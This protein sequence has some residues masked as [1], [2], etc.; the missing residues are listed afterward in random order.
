MI[1]REL[2]ITAKQGDLYDILKQKQTVQLAIQS[3][4]V[5]GAN[6][7]YKVTK[8]IKQYRETRHEK[9]SN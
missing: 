1:K 6:S 5:L 3:I 2:W 9:I 8:L 7:G 4:E